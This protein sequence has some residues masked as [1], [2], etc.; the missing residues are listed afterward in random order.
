MLASRA[1][2]GQICWSDGG[3]R[4]RSACIAPRLAGWFWP[5][6]LNLAPW[7]GPEPPAALAWVH[8]ANAN[9]RPTAAA[10]S[11]HRLLLVVIPAAPPFVGANKAN[12][13]RLHGRPPSLEK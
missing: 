1:G 5:L 11:P 3:V 13:S 7:S 10:A 4:I 12:K 8:L 2:G 9:P 6:T